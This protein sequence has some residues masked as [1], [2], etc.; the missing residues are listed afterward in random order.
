MCNT[1]YENLR[2]YGHAIP[3]RD[4]SIEEKLDD[5]GWSITEDDCWEWRGARNEHGYGV[6]TL[7]RKNLFNARVHRVMFERH[8]GPIEERLVVRHKCDNPP[9]CNPDHLELG[10]MADNSNDTKVRGR[11]WRYGATECLNGH[12]LTKPGSY[13]VQE[14]R[15]GRSDEKVCL[16]CQPERHL[17][18]QEKK[19]LERAKLR[20]QQPLMPEP[21]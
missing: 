1:H 17:R 8:F 5:T 3:R 7:V 18:W 20:T 11:H 16:T 15:K 2:K 6:I 4:W 13:R 12:D 10:T 14:R 19:K 9:C 21:S